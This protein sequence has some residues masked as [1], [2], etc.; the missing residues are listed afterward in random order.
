MKLNIMDAEDV[1][2]MRR[3]NGP[4]LKGQSRLEAKVAARPLTKVDDK[5]FRSE[6]WKRDHSRC[7]KCGRKVIKTIDLIPERGE[8]NHLHGRIGDLLFEAKC[9]LLMCATCH[10]QFTGKVNEKWIA[11]GT[12]FWRL[13]GVKVIDARQ[14]VSFE[15]IV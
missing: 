4:L 15:R 9:A 12:K 11:I 5:A 1:A 8:V 3:T 14:A 6:V 10:E 2:A 13:N 7:R